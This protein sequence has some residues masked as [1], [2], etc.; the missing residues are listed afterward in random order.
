MNIS[1]I[2]SAYYEIT[3]FLLS[4]PSDTIIALEDFSRKPPRVHF[5]DTARHR[6]ADSRNL[7]PT[8]PKTDAQRLKEHEIQQLYNDFLRLSARTPKHVPVAAGHNQGPQD[9]VEIWPISPKKDI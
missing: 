3:S 7:Q 6:H 8:K 2:T 9:N 5:A 4:I 1:R